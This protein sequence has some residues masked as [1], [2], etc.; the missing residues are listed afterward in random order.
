MTISK[1]PFY[2]LKETLK[3]YLE[4]LLM[5]KE[6]LSDHFYDKKINKLTVHGQKA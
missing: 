2:Q 6:V 5:K 1:Y 4:L 3:N